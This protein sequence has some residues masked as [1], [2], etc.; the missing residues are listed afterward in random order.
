MRCD[1]E[2]KEC[3]ALFIEFQTL[4]AALTRELQGSK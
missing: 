2:R 3:D 1:A 4:D